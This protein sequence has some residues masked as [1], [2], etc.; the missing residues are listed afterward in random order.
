MKVI[1]QQEEKQEN[2]LGVM[3]FPTFA[4]LKSFM[5]NFCLVKYGFIFVNQLW[6]TRNRPTTIDSIRVVKQLFMLGIY[7]AKL[8]INPLLYQKWRFLSG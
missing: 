6:S 1:F 4:S 8:R 7:S 5:I 3:H 2:R